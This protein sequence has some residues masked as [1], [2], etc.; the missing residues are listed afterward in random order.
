MDVCPRR[1]A[2]DVRRAA[3]IGLPDEGAHAGM[4]HRLFARLRR[5]TPAE[6]DWR[7]RELTHTA[8]DRLRARVSTPRWEPNGP[9]ES[10]AAAVVERLRT[11]PARFVID[12][13]QAAQA[14]DAILSRW[15]DAAR[16]AAARADRIIG[17][18]YDL[19][20]YRGLDFRQPGGSIDW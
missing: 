4:T 3:G 5:L 11:Q 15:P 14:R 8:I 2:A 20:G 12:P 1:M 17:G 6:L 13:L 9:F 10:I 19:L 7:A 16:D 18:H